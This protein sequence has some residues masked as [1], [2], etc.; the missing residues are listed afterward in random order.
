MRGRLLA[1]AEEVMARE[2]ELVE[3]LGALADVLTEEAEEEG[4]APAELPE[5]APWRWTEVEIRT[6]FRTEVPAGR[7]PGPPLD[8][9]RPVCSIVSQFQAGGANEAVK[10]PQALLRAQQVVTARGYAAAALRNGIPERLCNL[11]PS[12]DPLLACLNSDPSLMPFQKHLLDGEGE[13]ALVEQSWA[14]GDSAAHHGLDMRTYLHGHTADLESGNRLTAAVRFG[15][16]AAIGSGH[17]LSAHGGAISTALDEATAE[18]VKITHAPLATTAEISYKLTRP[19]DLNVSHRIECEVTEVRGG[20]LK[21]VVKGELFNPDELLCATC[22][23][24]LA[25]LQM[26]RK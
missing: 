12:D 6:F 21:I 26:L 13:Q 16:G 7:S 20:G 19:V 15:E 2:A 9:A 14:A 3:R 5:D 10:P 25:N 17:W 4:R 8:G 11:F 24:T 22:T 1:N 23:A 18:L